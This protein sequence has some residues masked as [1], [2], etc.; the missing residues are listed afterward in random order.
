MKYRIPKVSLR[1]VK[2]GTITIAS[3]KADSPRDAAAIAHAM[4]G[5]RS[6]EHILAIMLDGGN[7]V[8]NVAILG[9]GG[10]SSVGVKPGDILR[11]VLTSQASA[12]VLAHNH[13]SG[14]P[15]P[16]PEDIATTK[17][18]GAAAQLIGVPLLDHVIVTS[19]PDRWSS[20]VDTLGVP[21]V[22]S[23]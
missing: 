12:F 4:I 15:R 3:E 21:M 7:N 13:P 22:V 14:N 23:Q 20:I 5:D 17:A 1:M 2:D 9:Q 6:C 19:D 18:I 11:A 8:T 10:M 16:S